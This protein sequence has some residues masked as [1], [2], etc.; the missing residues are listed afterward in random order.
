MKI[1]L[2]N[3]NE[4]TYTN[5]INLLKTYK[6]VALD[7]PPS[8]GKSI[9]SLKYIQDGIENNEI[10]KVLYIT[11][12]KVAASETEKKID[13][14]NLDKDKIDVV[15]YSTIRSQAFLDSIKDKDYDLIVIDEYQHAGATVTSI[16]LQKIFEM[17]FFL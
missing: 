9:I 1:E 15:T 8:T 6:R 4:P 7:Q 12:W 11:S 14:Y 16:W 17:F 3:Y 10:N 5:L 2:R 13:K